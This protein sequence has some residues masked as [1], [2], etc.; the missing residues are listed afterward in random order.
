MNGLYGDTVSV[1][2]LVLLVTV[3][4]PYSALQYIYI[5]R[6]GLFLLNKILPGKLHCDPVKSLY[7]RLKIKSAQ[8]EVII[9]HTITN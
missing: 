4:N 3:C 8:V 6:P 1:L 5:T 9:I 2:E 7:E